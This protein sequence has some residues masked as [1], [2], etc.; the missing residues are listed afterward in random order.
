VLWSDV[1]AFNAPWRIEFTPSRIRD[2]HGRE[3]IARHIFAG[4]RLGTEFAIKP[5]KFAT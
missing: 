1:G 2:L 5:G 4:P 3:R